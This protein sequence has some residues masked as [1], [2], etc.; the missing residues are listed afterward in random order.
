MTD[1]TISIYWFFI[2]FLIALAMVF[3][4]YSLYGK[5][6]NIRGM[7]AVFLA[8]KVADCINQGG[9]IPESILAKD[10]LFVINNENFLKKCYLNLATESIYYWNN[11][12]IFVSINFVAIEKGIPIPGPTIF[13][14]NSNLNNRDANINLVNIFKNE[15]FPFC[16]ERKI[17]SKG[18]D[19]KF[20]LIQL[21]TCVRKTE[22]N[23]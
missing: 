15:K 23:V 14:G 11:D 5:P 1:K 22:K 20:Y 8:D 2:L 7:E 12:Q 17:Y 18:E 6:L 4:V 9:E 16:V 19:G 3:I 21:V 13:V 10:G